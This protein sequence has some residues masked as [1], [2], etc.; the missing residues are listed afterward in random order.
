MRAHWF[1]MFAF[2]LIFLSGA[3][4]VCDVSQVD[5][6]DVH[7]CC[8]PGHFLPFAAPPPGLSKNHHLS[9]TFLLYFSTCSRCFFTSHHTQCSCSYHHLTM[10][11]RTVLLGL[12]FGALAGLTSGFE[13]QPLDLYCGDMNCYDGKHMNKIKYIILF[14][15]NSFGLFQCWV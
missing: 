8:W 9:A 3:V 5:A 13:H 7:E 14:K 10:R 11:P 2:T 6:D 15:W 4:A 1:K 12:L